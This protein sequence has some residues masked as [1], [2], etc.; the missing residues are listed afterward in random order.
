MPS[1]WCHEENRAYRFKSVETGLPAEH[2]ADGEHWNLCES[3]TWSVALANGGQI[4]YHLENGTLY[5]SRD[6]GNHVSVL[7]SNG[8]ERNSQGREEREIFNNKTFKRLQE[9]KLSPSAASSTPLDL[10]ESKLAPSSSAAQWEQFKNNAGEILKELDCDF[11]QET[12]SLL[13]ALMNVE[14]PQC[15]PEGHTGPEYFFS[16]L[17]RVAQKEEEV[18]RQIKHFVA[19]TEFDELLGIKINCGMIFCLDDVSAMDFEQIEQIPGLDTLTDCV[20]AWIDPSG[21][22]RLFLIDKQEKKKSEILTKGPLWDDL[23]ARFDLDYHLATTKELELISNVTQRNYHSND[24]GIRRRQAFR[25]SKE[26]FIYAVTDKMYQKLLTQFPHLAEQIP[27]LKSLILAEQLEKQDLEENHTRTKRK[28]SE[29]D[30]PLGIPDE[31]T[32]K[33][34]RVNSFVSSIHALIE[35]AIISYIHA[36]YE[37]GLDEKIEGLKLSY[38]GKAGYSHNRLGVEHPGELLEKLKEVSDPYASIAYINLFLDFVIASYDPFV[39]VLIDTLSTMNPWGT[40]FYLD[41]NGRTGY[42]NYLFSMNTEAGLD[43]LGKRFFRLEQSI[44]EFRR[45]QEI[46]QPQ[47]HDMYEQD[48]EVLFPLFLSKTPEEFDARLKQLPQTSTLIQKIASIKSLPKANALKRPHLV[49]VDPMLKKQKTS[50]AFEVL[51]TTATGAVIEHEEKV[52]SIQLNLDED[53]FLTAVAKM[54]QATNEGL[55]ITNE[56]PREKADQLPEVKEFELTLPKEPVSLDEVDRIEAFLDE[57]LSSPL[58]LNC[59]QL[60]Q[61]VQLL[62]RLWDEPNFPF[63]FPFEQ[64]ERPAQILKKLIRVSRLLSEQERNDLLVIPEFKRLYEH[65]FLEFLSEIRHKLYNYENGY[66]ETLK[67]EMNRDRQY[68]QGIQPVYAKLSAEATKLAPSFTLT[69][70]NLYF[71][72][73]QQY[74]EHVSISGAEHDRSYLVQIQEILNLTNDPI[75]TYAQGLEAAKQLNTQHLNLRRTL[76]QLLGQA[77]T[78]GQLNFPDFSRFHVQEPSYLSM[79]DRFFA[80]PNDFLNSEFADKMRLPFNHQWAFA[81]YGLIFYKRNA[82]KRDRETLYKERGYDEVREA[83]RLLE[84]WQFKMLMLI[85]HVIHEDKI[86]KQIRACYYPIKTLEERLNETNQIDE[87]FIIKEQAKQ[88]RKVLKSAL[89]DLSLS[90]ALLIKAQL[91]HFDKQYQVL[92]NKIE[93]KLSA[94]FDNP[95]TLEAQYSQ[96]SIPALNSS[97]QLI[98]PTVDI[99]SPAHL[100]CGTIAGYRAYLLLRQAHAVARG[101]TFVLP[102]LEDSILLGTRCYQRVGKF[103]KK[104]YA[105]DLFKGLKEFLSFDELGDLHEVL[106]PGDEGRQQ[107]AHLLNRLKDFIPAQGPAMIAGILYKGDICTTIVLTRLGLKQYSVIFADSHGTS[108]HAHQHHGKAYQKPFASIDEAASYLSIHLPYTQTN[109]DYDNYNSISLHPASLIEP[110]EKQE[111]MYQQDQRYVRETKNQLAALQPKPGH[112]LQKEKA[113]TPVEECHSKL[114]LP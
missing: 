85:H 69:E 12:Q 110:N 103:G 18:T 93:K 107:Y 7:S 21:S 10:A 36:Y 54:M 112:S 76:G 70:L 104:L 100:A 68:L 43:E 77:D 34:I 14:L 27:N 94:C 67:I 50:V 29:L 74:I 35:Q 79:Q 105:E 25:D 30:K 87:L 45:A 97:K 42:Y 71:E 46:G 40:I 51:F 37:E 16:Y 78:K 88:I 95:N 57:A 91:K 101:E 2:S 20:I 83:A 52:A 3:G 102:S 33:R 62:S 6:Q 86:L 13:L 32:N 15:L 38:R 75:L 11:S 96:F 9:S 48:K 58:L 39:P 8:V 111:E 55:G 106:K 5:L 63:Q 28:P 113:E 98:I 24:E 61:Q 17:Y 72:I 41:M 90:G 82:D 31:A 44:F 22:K 73:A 80:C 66:H 47:S 81:L 23:F 56:E 60:Q 84:N 19:K 99:H 64:L 65:S 92:A 114:T 108:H 59:E 49:D 53:N 26:R 4:W 1:Y 89:G 109:A